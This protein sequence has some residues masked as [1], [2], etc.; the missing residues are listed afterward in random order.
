MMSKWHDFGNTHLCE[1]LKLGKKILSSIALTSLFLGQAM[2]FSDVQ[3]TSPL[4]IS[5]TYLSTKEVLSGYDDGSFKPENIINRAEAL[6]LILVATD[7][8]IAAVATSKFGDVPADAWF[9]K[10][11]NYAAEKGF[12]S[13]DD[14]TGLFVPAR[15]VN[16]AEFLKMLLKAFDIDTTKFVLNLKSNDVPDDAWFAPYVNFATKFEIMPQDTDGNAL[17]DNGLTR[18]EAAQIIFNMLKKGQGLDPQILLNL[19]ESHLL[20]TL[21]FIEA[22]N[23]PAAGLVVTMAESLS[24]VTAGIQS[25]A[26]NEVV[27]GAQKTSESLKH[28]VG[29][30]SAGQNGRVE[31]VVTA[32][33][34]SFK[35]AEAAVALNEKNAPMIDQIKKLAS[36]LATQA[37][38]KQTEAA[39]EVSEAPV[40]PAE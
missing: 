2:A 20:K 35:S 28:L 19:T 33:K 18:G 23:I 15:I 25:V 12:V 34:A 31:D 24:N 22:G 17:P 37:R 5:T 9:A 6:K 16:R 11:V 21:E 13:G 38:E 8:E 32:A 27:L 14:A 30:Y 29:A 10:Y 1:K 40:T 36:S 26:K 4:Y 3:I 7:E 39:Q